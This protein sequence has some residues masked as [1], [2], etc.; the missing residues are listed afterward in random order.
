MKVTLIADKENTA[1]HRL[2]VYTQKSLPQH[3]F[4]IVCFHPKRPSQ[5]QIEDVEAAIKWCDLVDFRYWKSAEVIK[6]MF[7]VK[8]PQILTHYNPYDITKKAWTEYK[9]NVVV[10]SEQAQLMRG[11]SYRI[12]LPVDLEYWQFNPTFTEDRMKVAIMV[13]NRIEA[14]KGVLP[15]A[16]ATKK[17]GMK[18]IL[19]GRPS[20]PEYLQR[21][22]AFDNVEF[23]EGISDDHLRQLYNRSGIHICNSIDTFESGTMPILESMAV[24]VPVLTRKVGHVPDIANGKNMVVRRGLPENVTELVELLKQMQADFEWMKRMREEAWSSIKNRCL[25]IYGRKYSQLYWKAKLQQPLVSVVIPTF[26]RVETLAKTIA[27]LAQQEW[28]HFEV[29]I[30]DDGSTDNTRAFVK[31]AAEEL[32]S[33]MT[34]KYIPT[35][36]YSFDPTA[37]TVR[38]L[39]PKTYGIAHA[40]NMGILNAEGKYIL[41][42]DDRLAPEPETIKSFMQHAGEKNWQWGIKDGARKGFVENFSFISRQAIINIGG[43]SDWITQY[44]GMTQEVR[45]RAE[46]NGIIFSICPEAQA[47]ALVKSGSKWK[48]LLQI[49]KSKAQ[50]YALG[51]E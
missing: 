29:L 33:R 21:V 25:E 40:R 24:G 49:A 5:Q 13:A 23:H 15:V 30:C 17:A 43:F 44:G 37:E 28:E 48:K 9:I 20:D 22:L 42:L 10:N 6:G 51:Y 31:L 4:T 12:P 39:F 14:K 32:A 34:I 45:K 46:T 2:C 16:E 7:D 1:I 8:K 27:A 26:N 38:G 36:R 35:A 18:L 3:Q 50:C 19:V 11:Q 41:F 47:H